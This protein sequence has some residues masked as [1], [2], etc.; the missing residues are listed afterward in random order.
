MELKIFGP[1]GAP[2]EDFIKAL[3]TLLDLGASARD[4][5]AE[6]FL[7]TE[8]FDAYDEVSAAAIAASSLLP[9]QFRGSVY[10]V[11]FLL[12]ALQVY[13]LKVLDIQRDLFTLGYPEKA[14]DHLGTLL[15][16]LE[17][18]QKQAYASFMRS[19]HENAILPTLEDIDVV[20]DMRPVFEDYVFPAPAKASGVNY[21][22]LIGFSYMVL[23]E[24]VTEDIEGKTRKLAFQMT[25]KSLADLQGALDRA[26][27]QLDILKASTR[28]IPFEQRD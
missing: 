5:L 4:E 9:E 20:C 22:S 15:R 18:V 14:I 6:W 17:P 27:E 13:S 25:E 2:D 10:A 26:R 7:A 21:R 23:V 3:P 1:S 24:L 12:E 16:R 11:R 28:E 19:E 8:T